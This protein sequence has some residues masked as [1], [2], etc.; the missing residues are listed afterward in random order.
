MA[1]QTSKYKRIYGLTLKEISEHL[2]LSMP[3][4]LALVNGKHKNFHPLT[5][6]RFREFLREHTGANPE[7]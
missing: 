3:T 2:E 7:S 6:R 5:L 4:V 1:K